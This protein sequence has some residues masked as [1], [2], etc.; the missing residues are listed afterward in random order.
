MGISAKILKVGK[1]MVVKW[2]HKILSIAWSTGEVPEDWRRAVIIPVHKKGS[3]TECSNSVCQQ[4]ACQD[5]GKQ[6]EAKDRRKDIES[7]RKVQEGSELHQSDIYS[8]A[9]Q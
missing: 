3:R 4:G 6:G 1:L 7:A 8:E 5:S 9:T 2:L